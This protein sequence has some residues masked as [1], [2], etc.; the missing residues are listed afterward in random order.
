MD[1]VQALRTYV[2]SQAAIN[3]PCI[4]VLAACL[5]YTHELRVS[6]EARS[7]NN[8]AVEEAKQAALTTIDHLEQALH[9]A[10]PSDAARILKIVM[11]VLARST[12][13]RRDPPVRRQIR[14]D[15]SVQVSPI[16]LVRIEGV[17]TAFLLLALGPRLGT[18]LHEFLFQRRSS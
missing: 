16:I 1:Y 10:E 6:G 5:V 9:D 8:K 2:N 11:D 14:S 4:K 17:T 13:E 18:D 12:T 7:T 3:E 15:R